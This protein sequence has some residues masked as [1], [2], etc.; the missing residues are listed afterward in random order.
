M[1][2]TDIREFLK[3]LEAEGELIRVKKEVKKLLDLF[4]D[5]SEEM[6]SGSLRISNIR[7]CG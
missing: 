7:I 5:D 6:L 4:G 1:S 3:L 2:F